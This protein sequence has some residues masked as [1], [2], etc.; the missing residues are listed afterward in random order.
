MFKIG[1]V[2]GGPS[3]ERGIS[4]NSARTLIDHL[5]TESIETTV[6]FVDQQSQFHQIDS[7]H[8]YSNTPSDFDFKM[9]RIANTLSRETFTSTLAQCDMIFPIIHGKFGEDGTLQKILEQANIPFVGTGSLA[10]QRAFLKNNAQRELSSAGFPTIPFLAISETTEA[11]HIESFWN[12]HCQTS[13]AIIKP[14]NAGSSLD[15]WQ[16]TT[17]EALLSKSKQMLT[18]HESAHIQPFFE[19]REMTLVV[20]SDDHGQPVALMP[21]ETILQSTDSKIF[22]YRS[23]YLPTNACRHHTPAPLNETEMRTCRETAEAIFRHF[24]L[25]DFARLDGWYCPEKGFICYDINIISGFEENSFLF[26]Q[27]AT[28]GMTH[29]STIHHILKSACERQHIALPAMQTQSSNAEQQV[30]IISGGGSSERQVSLMSGRNVWFKL[31]GQEGIQTTAF[32]L[33]KKNQVWQ[34]PYAMFLHHTVEEI[35]HD[36]ATFHDKNAIIAAHAPE[37][38]AKLRITPPSTY[39]IKPLS[40]PQW[41]DLILEKNASVL[42]ALHGGIGEDGT[43]QQ[44][45]AEHGIPFN[46]SGAATS[47]LCMNKNKTVQTIQSMQHTDILSQSQSLLTFSDLITIIDMEISQQELFWQKLSHGEKCIIKPMQ[48]GCSSGIVALFN[49]QDLY[50]YA[51]LMQEKKSTAP[52]NTF[53]N[54]PSPIELPS[55]CSYFLI[56]PF[57]ETDTVNVEN[58]QL[59]HTTHKGW[60]ELTI[61]VCEKNEKYK[62]LNPSITISTNA[63]LSVEEKFQGG[64]GINLTPP[65]ETL[66]S[67]KQQAHIRHLACLIAHE[68]NIAQ[69]ARLDI[70][71]NTKTEKLQLIEANTLPALTPSTVLFQQ[72]LAENPPIA[73]RTFLRDLIK[74]RKAV[75][76]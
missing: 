75:I 36:I 2:C 37:I 59:Q 22:D 8:L 31:S 15:V 11:T 45:L 48:D 33:D 44:L 14:N 71:Y 73:P 62:A 42:L 16:A 41:I 27:A 9:D 66:I 5:N 43:I 13:G 47:Q 6:F 21:T 60:L 53:Q 12:T 23:K 74:I 65:P 67:K 72:A 68:L 70:F 46:G 57:I 39:Q 25:K 28:C 64:T 50:Q 49:H 56:E 51:Q 18:L 30:F 26:K 24:D 17:A 3:L 19:G 55:H 20:I 7:A 40:L 35:E 1:I 54:Q 10:C 58:A 63:V 76:A 29:A 69:Y 34:L 61:V 52:A 4:L 38:A 32:F